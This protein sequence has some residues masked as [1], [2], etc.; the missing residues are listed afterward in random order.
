M[1]LNGLFQ[2]NLYIPLTEKEVEHGYIDIFLQRNPLIPD[3]KYEWVWEIKYL[4][5]KSWRVTSKTRD[6]ARAQLTKYRNAREF[7]GR[8]DMRFASI[9]FI[10]KDKF[11]IEEMK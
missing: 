4:P 11:E 5:V 2:S 10:G 3:V 7:A 6:A 8:S 9:I 1:L